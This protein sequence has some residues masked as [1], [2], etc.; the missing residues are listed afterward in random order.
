MIKVEANKI[1][2]INNSTVEEIKTNDPLD[3]IENFYS[4][5]KVINLPKDLP[6]SGVLVRSFVT[7]CGPFVATLSDG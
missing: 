4:K 5:N 7:F 3:S 1:S 6:F 2:Y